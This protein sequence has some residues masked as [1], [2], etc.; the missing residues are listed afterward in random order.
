MPT[1]SYRCKSCLFEFEEFQRMTDTALKTCPS[2]KQNTLVR[3]ID[4]GAGMVFKGNGFYI[5]DY[6]KSNEG[7]ESKKETKKKTKP[8]TESKPADSVAKSD[9]SPPKKE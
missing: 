3:I 8:S 5:T 2:C 9:T 6:K 1:Y 4:G 7:T